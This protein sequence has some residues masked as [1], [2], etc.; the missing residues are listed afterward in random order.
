MLGVLFLGTVYGVVVGVI[1]SFF[2]VIRQAVSPPRTFVGIRP[3]HEG[4]Y[5]LKAHEDA[6]PIQGILIYR[7]GGNLFFANIDTFVDDIE[8]AID[9]YTRVVIINASGINNVDITATDRV[10]ALNKSLKKRGI[11]FFITE[12]DGVVNEELIKY[13]AEELITTG[14]IRKE[15]DEV[16]SLVK[17]SPNVK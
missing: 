11:L 4:Y 10:M 7:F 14:V 1:L 12:N 13:G 15:I 16:I 6:E 3:G 5:S 17:T 9:K 8:N 2:A